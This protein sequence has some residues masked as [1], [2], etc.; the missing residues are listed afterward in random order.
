FFLHNRTHQEEVISFVNKSQISRVFNNLIKN[1]IQAKKQ[2]TVQTITIEIENYGGK[3]W[4][5]KIT[6]TGVGMTDEVK[7]KIFSPNFTTKTSGM[8]LGLAMVQRIVTTWGGSISFESTYN[9]GTTFFITLPK[10]VV[11]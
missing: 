10:Y 8:G 11:N 1:A 9:T 5:I 2:D 4:Q 6:D 7:E 3:M